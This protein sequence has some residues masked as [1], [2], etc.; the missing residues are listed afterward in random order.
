MIMSTVMELAEAASLLS[1]L[2]PV[3]VHTAE[4]AFA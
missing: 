4:V 1:A 2:G 3:C